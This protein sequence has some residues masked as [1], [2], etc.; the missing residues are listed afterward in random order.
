MKIIPKKAINSLTA[1]GFF[2]LSL[3]GQAAWAATPAPAKPNPQPPASPAC[4]SSDPT[5]IWADAT[6][7]TAALC[8]AQ[9]TAGVTS[10]HGIPYVVQQ[11]VP[12]NRWMPSAMA[13]WPPSPA[14]Q[15]VNVQNQCM[16]KL[17]AW[18]SQP[19]ATGEDCLYL[20]VWAP[21][22]SLNNPTAKLPVMVFI[23]G[24]A[25]V[26]GSGSSPI[27]D[28]AALA[29]NGVIVVT[30]NYRLGALGFM[31]AQVPADGTKGAQ[32][33]DINGNFG[34]DD[35]RNALR[36]VQANIARFG[37][38]PSQVTLFGESAGAM[39]TGLH[40]F[41]SPASAPLFQAAI[42]E[43][44]PIGSLY[45]PI[46]DTRRQG[47]NFIHW[48]CTKT[49]KL[50]SC[51]GNMAWLQGLSAGTILAAQADFLNLGIG[52]GDGPAPAGGA[53]ADSLPWA[54]TIDG[55]DVVAQPI[56]GFA[57]GMPQKPFLFGVNADEGAIFAA[58]I[59]AG[60]PGIY[61]PFEYNKILSTAIPDDR[62]QKAIA[63]YKNSAGQKPYVAPA[64]NPPPYFGKTKRTNGTAQTTNLLINDF[65]FHCANLWT[66]GQAY[67]QIAGAK[68][69]TPI[70]GYLFGQ[71][72][73]YDL[74]KTKAGEAVQ[75]CSPSN[76][77]VC[78]A[79]ELPYV[80]S[81]LNVL[82]NQPP[83]ADSALAGAMTTIW[84]G[85][86]KNP[87]APAGLTA[88]SPS[89]SLT[90]FNSRASA[91]TMPVSSLD[92]AGNCSALWNTLGVYPATT[93][94]TTASSQP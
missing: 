85:F 74:Y 41:A 78:H 14:M 52:N 24:G 45:R 13:S 16:Q 57:G 91:A 37:G 19:P 11:P 77:N 64:T 71:Q 40:L 80:F 21:S 43:S 1:A 5:T 4:T 72:P 63:A 7:S 2:A 25:F 29:K 89:G 35:Q 76:G 12:P 46:A 39:S 65:A 48:L 87:L 22:A 31:A 51:P 26:L 6:N 94:Q 67:G 79:N 84:A 18:N 28:G 60:I 88:Y 49:L 61:E 27:Y 44:N 47:T 83:Q 30:L 3:L 92:Q 36:W 68:G 53:L 55:S 58:M 34:L 33:V 17:P 56:A 93:R 15:A 81:T 82:V 66:A 73:I 20:N 59:A 90:V 10:Y 69:T 62:A 38:D 86:A 9:E 54:P 23:H 50:L 42:M 32:T 8:G 70:Y 75:A